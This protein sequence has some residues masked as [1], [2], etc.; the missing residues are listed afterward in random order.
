MQIQTE[1]FQEAFGSDLNMVVSSPT[2]SGKTVVL[3]LAI[4]RLLRQHISATGALMPICAG[5]ARRRFGNPNNLLNIKAPP[6][7]GAWQLQSGRLKAVYVAPNKA[8][9]QERVADWQR[10][11]AY[12][13][14][15][16]IECTGDSDEDDAKALLG[17]DLIATT[18]CASP[19]ARSVQPEAV[20]LLAC[21][22]I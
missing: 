18:P 14:V 22:L 15:S 19:S 16:V 6:C 20:G 10:R 4:L 12:L 8:L 9:V 13:G 3:E 5:V 1:C 2:G 7:A 21:L 11:F 17:A